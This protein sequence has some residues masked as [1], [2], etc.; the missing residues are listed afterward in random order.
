MTNNIKGIIKNQKYDPEYEPDQKFLLDLRNKIVNITN[1]RDMKDIKENKPWFGFANPVFKYAFL[2]SMVFLIGAGIYFLVNPNAKPTVTVAYAMEKIKYSYEQLVKENSIFHQRTVV[3]YYDQEFG[4]SD[5]SYEIWEDMSSNRMKNITKYSDD[6][7]YQVHD[8]NTYWDYS[9]KSNMVIIEKYI[10]SDPSKKDVKL[11]NRVLG[12]LSNYQTLFG[13]DESN[14]VLENEIIDGINYIVLSSRSKEHLN[15]AEDTA[16]SKPET[17]INKYYFDS[18]TFLL[19]RERYY[20][21]TEQDMSLMMETIV[22]ELDSIERTEARLTEIFTFDV[23]VPA[24]AV[25][26]ERDIFV[27]DGGIDD[28]KVQDPDTVIDVDTDDTDSEEIPTSNVTPVNESMLDEIE[29][30]IEFYK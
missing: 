1:N 18:E 9:T 21:A 6:M 25:Y 11:G 16:G 28:S 12:S 30:S 26:E 5:I 8:G 22:E 2:T 20:I 29:T 23:T 3:K 24:D 7:I 14:F 15:V 19:R 13:I 17:D 27:D 4:S 10:Y